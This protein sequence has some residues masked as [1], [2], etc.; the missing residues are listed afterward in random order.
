MSLGSDEA[1]DDDGAFSDGSESDA[2]STYSDDDG[3]VVD[4]PVIKT[5]RG[6]SHDSESA[7]FQ[8]LDA[9]KVTFEMNKIIED[10][11]SVLRLSA[12]ICRL[13]LHHYK[14]NKESLLE[15]FYESTDMDSFFLDANI[16]S[17]FKVARRGDE[18]LADIVDTCV[19]CCNRTILTGL[20]CSHRFCYPCWDSYLT[21]KVAHVACPQHNCP[22]IVD[23]EKTLALVK[24][25][26]AKKR[27]RRLIINSFVEC[28]RLLRWCPAADCG[29]VIEVGHLEARPVKCTCGTVFCFACGHEWHEPVN[30]RLLKLWIKKCNDD[31]ETSNWISANTKEC[32]KCQVTIEKDGGCNHMTCKNVACK[33]EFCWMCLGPWE[34]HGSSW[35]SCNRY[36]DTLAKQA[37]DA[38][39]RS[40]AALQRYLHYYNRYMNH[41]QS[42]K[43]EHKLYSIV[44]SKMEV[45]QQ[46]NMSWIEVQFLRKAVDVLSECRRT[47]MYTYAFAFYLQK[48]NQSVIFEENQR[49]LEHATEQLSEFLERDLDHENL[50][51]L[52]QKVQDKYRYVEQ[53]RT[54]LLKHCAEGVEHD[55]WRFEKR[56]LRYLHA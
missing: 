24:S 54:T 3:I 20:Q 23:D 36:D 13:L 48:D 19:I 37:R 43:L 11:A 46:A 38:Q 53:R 1:M 40:R 45:M 35:Y 55:F 49:D 31:S 56:W 51:S 14:W 21:T 42:L 44:K 18:G 28:N 8:V 30:C 33:M 34:P 9:E 2:T 29:R 16:I 32:P 12:T 39:E 7:D 25:E 50:V 47:L 5:E 41:Q 6:G 17:P 4:P 27:Y 52:K 10:V 22:I 15:R 26:N